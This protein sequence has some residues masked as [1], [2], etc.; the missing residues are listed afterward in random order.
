VRISNNEK[1]QAVIQLTS[2]MIAQVKAQ[3][4]T[5]SKNGFYGVPIKGTKPS[6]MFDG[7]CGE[8]AVAEYLDVPWESEYIQNRAKQGD[9]MGYQVKT[10][11]RHDGKLLTNPNKTIHG[12]AMPAGIYILVTLDSSQQLATIRGWE[13]SRNLWSADLWQ[14]GM[15]D[16]CY[17]QD[18]E[19]L[20]PMKHLPDTP[21]MRSFKASWAS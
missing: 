12:G 11:L 20:N 13:D 2:D 8:I 15:P 7:Y 10:T 18:Q 3:V 14:P 6:N 17:A 16:P 1:N 5:T 19:H 21:Q 9:V 4:D